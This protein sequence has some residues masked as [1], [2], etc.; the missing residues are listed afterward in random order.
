[1]IVDDKVQRGRRANEV[2]GR[3]PI[4]TTWG[5][6][7]AGMIMRNEQSCG[8]E[9]HSLAQDCSDREYRFAIRASADHI[10]EQKLVSGVQIQHPDHLP[11]REGHGP[12]QVIDDRAGVCQRPSREVGLQ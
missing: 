5:R 11:P 6:I 8:V 7:A 4:L 12:V 10:V 9:H 2:R 1:M 3:S